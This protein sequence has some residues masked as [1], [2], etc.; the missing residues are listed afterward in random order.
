MYAYVGH[1]VSERFHG[2]SFYVFY[3]YLGSF[4]RYFGFG[5]FQARLA[6]V[7]SGAFAL[8]GVALLGRALF[9]P[10]VGNL[11]AALLVVDNNFLGNAR[12]VKGNMLAAV[13]Y[14]ASP[15]G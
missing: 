4:F 9:N 6:V 14:L 13:R 1:G 3:L 10:G 7:L 2:H 12:V 8:V 15:S 11:V 5:L